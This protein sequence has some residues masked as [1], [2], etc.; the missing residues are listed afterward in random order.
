MA[1]EFVSAVALRLTRA[2]FLVLAL[3]GECASRLKGAGRL[4]LA[5]ADIDVA[6]GGDGAEVEVA[7]GHVLAH[8]G[9]EDPSAADH[10]G[11]SV[12]V[13]VPAA[14]SGGCAIRRVGESLAGLVDRGNDGAV[15]AARADE[16]D[17]AEG[18]DGSGRILADVGLRARIVGRTSGP[19]AE[20]TVADV[21]ESR[22]GGGFTEE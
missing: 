13:G 5:S 16:V 2:E 11:S 22:E 19:V 10:A 14:F 8:E 9:I 12:D 15:G 1:A 3:G 21:V 6:S 7:V 4:A 17:G 20:D 18:P